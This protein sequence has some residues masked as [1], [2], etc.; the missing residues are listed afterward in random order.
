MTTSKLRPWQSKP[1]N[2][3]LDILS[4]SQNAVDLS[5]TGT[6][7]TYVACAVAFLLRQPTVAVVP[8][9]AISSWLTAIEHFDTSFPVVGYEAVRTGRTSLGRWENQPRWEDNSS[10]E[11]FV[12]ESCQCVVDFDDYRPCYCHPAGLHCIKTKRKPWK[13]GKFI[14]DDAIKFIIFDEVHRCS[15]LDSLNAD[16]LISAKRQGIRVLGLSATAAC[17]P[18]QMRALGYALGLHGLNQ[19]LPMCRQLSAQDFS[20][21]PPRFEPIKTLPTFYQWAGYHGCRP[22]PVYRG[23]K[24]FASAA[25]QAEI[26]AD[27]HTQLVPSRGVRVRTTDI[28]DFPERQVS[29]ELYDLEKDYEIEKLYREMADALSVLSDR[30]ARD[31]N[32]ESPLTR[33]LRARQ[34]IELLKVPIF[35]ELAT[36]AL[37]K[38]NSVAIFVCFTASLSELSKRLQCENIIDGSPEGVRTRERR[39]CAFQSN[40]ERLILLNNAAGGVAISLHDVHGGYPRV[41]LV[42]PGFSAV[43]FRQVLGRLHRAGAKSPALYRVIL[44]ANTVEIR[45]KRAL[46]AKNHCIDALC[47]GDLSPLTPAAA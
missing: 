32:T 25:R 12:C 17:T 11:F 13:Y 43:E 10:N 23:L 8:K 15:G 42:S 3:L 1:V 21:D 47:D 33:I 26:M 19:N 35:V 45:I 37:A 41:G 44:A 27:I 31:A 40:E 30:E 46:D 34:R 4:Y 20:F 9:I 39:L 18:L 22:D 28:P 29:A 24:W 14:W 5:D 36:D 16:M 38:G 7:K 6:G 2:Q